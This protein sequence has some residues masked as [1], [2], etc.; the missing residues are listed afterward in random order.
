MKTITVAM[1]VIVACTLKTAA[2]S[3]LP[4]RLDRDQL[5]TYTPEWKGERFADGRPKVSDGIIERMKLNVTIN[6]AWQTLQTAGYEHQ[7]ERG[8]QRVQP[9][10]GPL[11]GRALTATFMPRRPDI[12]KTAND[13]GKKAGRIGGQHTWPVKML[14]PGDV[15]VADVYGK[16]PGTPI[17]GASL[18]TAI[19]V[20]SGNGV[21]FDGEIR[22]LTE[23]ERIKGFN[24]FV[25]NFNPSSFSAMLMGINIPT[26]IGSV[27]VMPGDIVLGGREGIIFVPAH[28]AEQVVA[29]AEMSKLHDTF[30]FERMK[31]KKYVLEQV[32]GGKWT[33][34]VENDFYSWLKAN[35]DRLPVPK[36]QVEEILK[37]KSP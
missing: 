1:L 23:I 26:R 19:V 5:I 24:G 3:N 7:F 30:A 32:Y 13:T 4:L 27:T 31:E 34:E 16:E 28:L 8:W 17:V 14:V 22:D 2:A 18:A 6:Q 37:K 15:Y 11:V 20:N 25:R 12:F 35:I 21:V 9:D 36:A 10:G 29:D 33:D